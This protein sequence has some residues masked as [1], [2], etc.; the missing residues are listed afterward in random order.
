VPVTVLDLDG[1]VTAQ[2][3]F[4]ELL[5]CGGSRRI[6]ARHLAPDLRIIST[7][8]AHYELGALLGDLAEDA[9]PDVVFYGSGD[10]H[11]VTASLLA[12]HSAPLSVIHFDNHPDWVFWPARPNCGGWV[13]RA[14]DLPH[15][16]RIVTLGPASTDLVRPE[17]QLANLGAIESG[18]LEV[19]PWQQ[20]RSRVFRHH[21]D[22]ACSSYDRRHL[23][24]RPLALCDWGPFI[25][26]VIDRL[27]TEAVYIT[28]DKDVLSSAEATTNW[29]QGAMPLDHVVRAIEMIAARCRIVGI[30]VCGDYSQPVFRDVFRRTLAHFDHPRLQPPTSQALTVNAL[31]N[32]RLLNV[33]AAIL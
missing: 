25:H 18:R 11:H 17:L 16:A 7:L 6:D 19:Y 28:I 3:P 20:A 27:P 31:T 23:H 9:P 22:S 13:C 14:L 2:A 10:F 1:A 32:Q 30:D 21:L 24:W 29:D 33:F 4:S 15:V 26:D 5:A 8:A 12:R